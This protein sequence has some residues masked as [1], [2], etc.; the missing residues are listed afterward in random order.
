MLTEEATEG[1]G[2]AVDTTTPADS[3]TG[4]TPTPKG[5]VMDQAGRGFG[6]GKKIGK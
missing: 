3:G 6:K 5:G 1:K 2:D 4:P